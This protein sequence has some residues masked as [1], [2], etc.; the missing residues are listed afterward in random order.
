[1]VTTEFPAFEILQSM[2]IFHLESLNDK[3]HRRDDHRTEARDVSDKI[4]K[5]SNV[6]S[7]DECALSS[8]FA[9]YHPVAQHKFESAADMEPVM[10]WKAALDTPP[11][12]GT[13]AGSE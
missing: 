3:V 4:H 11:P 8:Q 2:S 9:D 13:Q 12:R 10:A 1:M 7:L 6:L 5:V